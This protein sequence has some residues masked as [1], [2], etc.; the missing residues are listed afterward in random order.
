MIGKHGV[1]KRAQ[2]QDTKMDILFTEAEIPTEGM[3]CRICLE[4]G[5]E[6]NPLIVPC[7]CT[8]SIRFVHTACIREWIQRQYDQ[9]AKDW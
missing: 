4:E 1:R 3:E 7:K 6:A 2:T 9:K 5:S 8:G